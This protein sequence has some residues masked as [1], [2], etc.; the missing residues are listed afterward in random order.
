[1]KKILITAP[2]HQ[3]VKIFKEY[4]WSLNRLIIPEGYEAIKYFYLHNAENLKKFLQPNEYELVKDNVVRKQ[5]DITHIWE[6]DNFSVVS[7]MRTKALIKAREEKFDYLF[8]VDS[9][10]ILCKQTLQELIEDNKDFVSKLHWSQWIKDDPNSI[11]PNCYDG[12]TKSGKKFYFDSVEKFHIPGLYEVGTAGGCNLIS[13]RI[14]NEELINYYP[15]KIL[16]TSFWEDFAFSTR[17]KCVIPDIKF[18]IDSKNPVKHLY[19]QEDYE[20]WIKEEKTEW[21]KEF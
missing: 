8:S 21:I 17:C 3:D 16:S 10:T 12:I 13:S 14:F 5:S 4:L 11:G 9:D 18:Y 20:K 2:V 6:K 7:E 19:R 1:M 15:I